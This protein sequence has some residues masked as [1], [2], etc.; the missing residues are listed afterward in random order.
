MKRTNIMLDDDQHR[1]LKAYAQKEKRTIGG[2]VRE[3]IDTTYGA[4]NRLEQ[5]KEIALN[6]YR[7]GLIS[8]GKLAE[9]IGLDPVSARLYLRERG[10]PQRVQDIED[11]RR[12]AENA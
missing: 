8:L 12:D 3:A 4:K 5:R 2:L 7:E 6:A 1:S 9:V 10:I 11:I